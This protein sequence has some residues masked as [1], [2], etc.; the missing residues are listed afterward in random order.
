MRQSYTFFRSIEPAK[1]LSLLIGDH[2]DR[3]GHNEEKKSPF[4]SYHRRVL[5]KKADL[6]NILKML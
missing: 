2:E 4:E 6:E 1:L 3:E 5:C